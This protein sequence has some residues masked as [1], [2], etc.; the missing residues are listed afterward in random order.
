MLGPSPVWTQD[1][2]M[3]EFLSMK[4]SPVAASGDLYGQQDELMMYIRKQNALA[5]LIGVKN[6]W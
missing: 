2:T 6:P 4:T 1:V 5:Q 3:P